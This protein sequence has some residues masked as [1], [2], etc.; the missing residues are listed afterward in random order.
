MKTKGD[1]IPPHVFAAGYATETNREPLF[2]GRTRIG[3][4]LIPGKV[5]THYKTCYI[6]Y[7]NRE[8]EKSE[9]EILVLPDT[10]PD[11]VVWS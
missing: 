1:L 11:A 5:H 9:Y 8:E 6:P 3:D 2:I 7:E 4:N 10:L